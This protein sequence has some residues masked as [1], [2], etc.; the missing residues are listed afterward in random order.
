M[1]QSLPGEWMELGRHNTSAEDLF[2]FKSNVAAEAELGNKNNEKNE[3]LATSKKYFSITEKAPERTAV[4]LVVNSTG[5]STRCK[6]I[7]KLR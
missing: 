6:V 3:R 5:F 2:G 1:V 4:E 7:L